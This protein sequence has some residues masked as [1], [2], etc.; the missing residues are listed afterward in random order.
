M[1]TNANGIKLKVKL[2]IDNPSLGNSPVFFFSFLLIYI[3]IFVL[4]CNLKLS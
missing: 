3:L 2:C 4:K 1:F